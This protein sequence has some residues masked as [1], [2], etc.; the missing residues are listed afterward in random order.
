MI[1]NGEF[2]A[3]VEQVRKEKREAAKAAVKKKQQQRRKALDLEVAEFARKLKEIDETP[4]SELDNLPLP[5]VLP[6]EPLVVYDKQF[7]LHLPLI[8]GVCPDCA[9]NMKIAKK[10]AKYSKARL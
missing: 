2:E 6:G 8:R 5:K 9:A 4:I 3:F 7:G 10:Q 1:A